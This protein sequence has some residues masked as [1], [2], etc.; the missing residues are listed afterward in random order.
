M[1]SCQRTQCQSFYGL[2]A[3]E[4]NG[5]VE[6]ARQVAA[7]WT[8]LTENHKNIILKFHLLFY[9][10]STHQFSIRLWC[11]MKSRLHTMNGNDQLSGWTEKKLQRTSQSQTCTKKRSWSV[12]GGLLPTWSTTAFWILAKPLYPGSKLSKM[13]HWRLQYLQPALVNIKGPV[14]IHSNACLNACR[15]KASKVEW[16]GLQSFA[17]SALTKALLPNQPP[18]LQ[19]SWQLFSG[20]ILP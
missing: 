6:K 8:E 20:K 14:L 4:A 12:F 5:K 15:T 19:V 2:S 9:T 13:I 17:S 18:L 1:R 11:V 3:C 7:S 16:I 10:T